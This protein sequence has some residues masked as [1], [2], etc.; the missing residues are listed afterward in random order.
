MTFNWVKYSIISFLTGI[1]VFVLGTLF[2]SGDG[3]QA[4]LNDLLI[5]FAIYQIYAFI[6]GF[7]NMYFFWFVSQKISWETNFLKAVLT[8]FSGSILLTALALIVLRYIVLVLFLG[9]DPDTFLKNSKMYFIFGITITAIISLIFYLFYFYKAVTEEKISASEVKAK[10]ENAK[11]ESLKSQ[12]DP[13]FL[14]NSLNVLTSLIGENPAMAERFTTQLSKVYRYV[15]EQKNKDLIPL[16][17]ELN[18]ARTYMELL[19]MRFEDAVQFDIPERSGNPEF[20]I[21]PLSLQILLEN[22]VKHNVISTEDPLRIKIYESDGLFI[23]ENKINKKNT[24][25]KSTKVGLQNIK[26][27]YKLITSRPVLISR[28][29]NLFRVK[30]PLLTQK[31][32]KMNIERKEENKYIRARKK[33]DALKEF[34]GSLFSYIIVIP[35]LFFI[36]YKYTPG[37]IQWF[38]FPALGWGVG[39][40][41]QG[42]KVFGNP[43][44]GDNWEERKVKEFMEKDEPKMW[45]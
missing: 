2:F 34:Y 30:L 10:T 26:D 31:I 28:E 33:V 43:I 44:F 24:L 37:V 35:F 23:I 39:L 32:K 5:S 13:H 14:F 25:E 12:L 6:L 20:K 3:F 18:F 42:F 8:G 15:L 7:V 41:F 19:K 36:W 9:A 29:N 45:H 17:E 11:Y 27:R 40:I 16:D 38:W 21:V 1:I 4:S 22:A